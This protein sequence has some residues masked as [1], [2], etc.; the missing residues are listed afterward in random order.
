MAKI[1]GIIQRPLLTGVTTWDSFMG[2]SN[3]TANPVGG[4]IYA[5]NH[6][7]YITAGANH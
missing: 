5:V 7:T 4:S 1:T 6:L 2:N 3:S